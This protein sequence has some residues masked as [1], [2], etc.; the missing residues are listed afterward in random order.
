M[1]TWNCSN[2][3]EDNFQ[4]AKP[5]LPSR[6]NVSSY[7][8]LCAQTPMCSSSEEGNAL[9]R[10]SKENKGYT[11]D[12]FKGFLMWKREALTRKEHAFLE[13]L[14]EE[15]QEEDLNRAM[16][17]L[18]NNEII[19]PIQRDNPQSTPAI[20]RND[21][22]IGTGRSLHSPK[23]LDNGE[24]EENAP[25]VVTCSSSPGEEAFVD[26]VELI[27]SEHGIV[28]LQD[29]VSDA[30]YE[31]II[32]SPLRPTNDEESNSFK[33]GLTHTAGEEH[34]N[35]PKTSSNRN[36]SS[37]GS[38]LRQSRVL[39]RKGS[40]IH[41]NM[42]KA[43]RQGFSL[44]PSASMTKSISKSRQPSPFR[45][46][47][48]SKQRSEISSSNVRAEFETDDTAVAPISQLNEPFKNRDRYQDLQLMNTIESANTLDRAMYEDDYETDSNLNLSRSSS[49]QRSLI[50]QRDQ[51]EDSY[52]KN[53]S[54][55]RIF[56]APTTSFQPLQ[57]EG[58]SATTFPQSL[59]SR[60][61]LAD[62]KDSSSCLASASEIV[63]PSINT[64][65]SIRQ[66]NP[67]M[68]IESLALSSVT[69]KSTMKP[70]LHR[71]RSSEGSTRDPSR[72][73]PLR[74]SSP[75]RSL[76]H[77]SPATQ[78]MPSPIPGHMSSKFIDTIIIQNNDNLENNDQMASKPLTTRALEKMRKFRTMMSSITLDDS[79]LDTNDADITNNQDIATTDAQLR[80]LSNLRQCLS[81]TEYDG[82]RVKNRSVLDTDI[83]YFD[84]SK[85]KHYDAWDILHHERDNTLPFQILGTSADDEAS[86][87]HV[88]SPPL[89]ES[90]CGFLPFSCSESNFFMKYSL[91]RDGASFIPM[92]QQI[93][94]SKHTILAIET[95]DGEVFGAFTS[96]AWKICA[97]Y[98]GSGESFLWRMKHDRR[99]LCT[100]VFDQANLESE[101]DFFP[102]TGSNYLVQYCSKERLALGGGDSRKVSNGG[103]GLAVESQCLYGTSEQSGTFDNPP[104]S[105]VH[106]DGTPFEIVNMEIWSM[107]P[108]NTETEAERLE[109]ATLFLEEHM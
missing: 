85:L 95:T 29:I 23:E 36:E 67:L 62:S 13:K 19:F 108:A 78:R 30:S 41:L 35:T 17:V 83:D 1:S 96:T 74:Q 52:L 106:V 11:I 6:N 100:S 58:S 28:I 87:P 49:F 65:P 59:Q 79:F 25:S 93:R 43:H 21:A 34:L 15:G 47:S 26:G 86:M 40:F 53:D 77:S 18:C 33:T 24:R 70:S 39:E 94:G 71:R 81:A 91:I 14:V 27:D 75:M 103:F 104:L 64:F 7:M 82:S 90:L 20:S 63:D 89:M 22:V 46:Y 69:S 44:T 80:D 102:W 61:P 10:I 32:T 54:T 105:K 9:L 98:Y 4:D 45:T 2:L 68:R 60:N 5:P 56:D 50:N 66:A 73:R 16:K 12:L 84:D 55:T 72:M 48:A 51:F 101:V 31:N 107:T 3:Y 97:D 42:W 8:T 92:L 57:Q 76:L 99:T 109:M 38:Q 37:M 88:L